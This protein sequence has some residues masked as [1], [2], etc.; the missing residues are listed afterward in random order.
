MAIAA[1]SLS[2]TGGNELQLTPAGAFKGRDGRPHEVPSWRIDAQLAQRLIAAAAARVTPYVIDYEHQTLLAKKN[3]KPAP[4]A[5]WFKKLEWREGVGL[6]A[7][8]VQWTNRA[9]AMIEANEYKFISP[10]IAYDDKTGDVIGLLM[11]AV[12][13]NPAIDGMEEVLIAAA[14]SYFTTTTT[15]PE[16][17][18]SM[19]ALL[20]QLRWL[21]NLP[22][23][24]SA[25]DVAQHLQTLITT[26]KQDTAVTAAASFD[27]AR[28]L[29]D[30]RTKVATLSAAV[31]DPAR[32]VPIETMAT[33]QGRIAEL[34]SE[35][36]TG[37][38]DG[39]V[40]GALAS[41]KLL[42]AQEAWA[43][44][45]GAKDT[46]G[47]SAFLDNAP[48]IAVLSGTQTG[49]QPPSPS[50]TASLT[51][52]QKQLCAALGVSEADYLKTLQAECAA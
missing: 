30:Y 43:R 13:N 32:Y 48:P 26:L 11:A 28:Y 41:G 15:S 39:L 10:V 46:A 27:L 49:G 38:V 37:K 40:K 50:P 5:G 42:P 3:G 45:F 12:T 34:S 19:D 23:G 1:C 17:E 9:A 16:Q 18:N 33:L 47:L 51:A 44:E 21:L 2:L 35:I 31:P 24:A 25:E 29:T 52:Q 22:V 20:E 7:I 6:F 4:A 14:S 36:S 8:D